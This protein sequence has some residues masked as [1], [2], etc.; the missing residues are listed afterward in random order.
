M[1]STRTLAV[2]CAATLFALGGFAPAHAAPAGDTQPAPEA[3]VI[4][5]VS[6]LSSGSRGLFIG[7]T[8]SILK[9]GKY[10]VT[11]SVKPKKCNGKVVI[12][13][14]KKKLKTVT[15]KKGKVTYTFPKSL[16]A[17][18][19]TITYSYSRPGGTKRKPLTW[20]QT[21]EV[22]Q[23]AAFAAE[24]PAYTGYTNNTIPVVMNIDYRGTLKGA[25]ITWVVGGQ[26]DAFEYTGRI[27]L[28]DSA[29]GFT[30]QVTAWF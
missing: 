15:L 16:K 5:T 6:D 28:P 22:A 14:G 21:V 1:R 13:D 8:D 20:K 4:C 19:H 11:I 12:K 2:A 3:I 23:P 26:A 25:Q 27:A 29:K 30:G 17:G 24:S 7:S 18:T 9:G 10:K